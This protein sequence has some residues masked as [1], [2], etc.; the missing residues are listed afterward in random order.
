MFSDDLTSAI[1]EYY[2]LDKNLKEMA[3]R[4]EKLGSAIKKAVS[5]ANSTPVVVPSNTLSGVSYK[6]KVTEI[7]G[8]TTYD[9]KAAIAD[10]VDLSP[11]KKVGAP[12]MTLSVTLTTSEEA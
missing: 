12:Y 10:G 9:T 4:K 7:A 6:V 2:E 11:Y 8:R 3:K 5:V 1:A